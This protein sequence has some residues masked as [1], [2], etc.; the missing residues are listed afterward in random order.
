[1]DINPEAIWPICA[2]L[3]RPD[4]HAGNVDGWWVGPNRTWPAVDL[5]QLFDPISDPA[6]DMMPL[7]PTDRRLWQGQDA[8]DLEDGVRRTMHAIDRR[9]RLHQ[10]GP[11]GSAPQTA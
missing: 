3:L 4:D 5:V 9:E 10:V 6:S 1:M 2:I 7:A 11:H 8:G